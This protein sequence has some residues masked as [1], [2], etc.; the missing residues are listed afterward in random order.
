MPHPSGTAEATDPP[1]HLPQTTPAEGVPATPGT[2]T[3]QAPDPDPLI[4]LGPR[5]RDGRARLMPSQGARACCAD[6]RPC[7]RR[8]RDG[9]PRSARA[10][11]AAEACVYWKS[12]GP[13]VCSR[14]PR[15]ELPP[16]G[17]GG[18]D[19]PG[20]AA[21]RLVGT[22]SSKKA[23]MTGGSA[24]PDAHSSAAGCARTPRP[25]SAWA[26]RGWGG[27]PIASGRDRSVGVRPRV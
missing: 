27:S 4:D 17:G 19:G 22:R 9:P 8:A 6:I 7:R 1:G 10:S 14:E 2:A 13:G 21:T 5:T 23:I 24:A 16:G 12:V 11:R 15:G 25:A 20:P 18:G 3:C 26:A